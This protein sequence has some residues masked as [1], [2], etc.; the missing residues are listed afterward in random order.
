[1]VMFLKINV[2]EPV[3]KP[4]GFSTGSWKSGQIGLKSGPLFLL[5]LRL[6][7]QNFSFGTASVNK[8]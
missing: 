5:N 4:Y 1:M 3:P 2:S 8:E 7:F 6:L